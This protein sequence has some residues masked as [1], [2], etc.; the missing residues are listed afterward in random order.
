MMACLVHRNLHYGQTKNFKD[1]SSSTNRQKFIF[2]LA[3]EIFRYE[4]SH[5][6]IRENEKRM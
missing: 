6:F 3:T 5:I 1:L 2:T 4:Y